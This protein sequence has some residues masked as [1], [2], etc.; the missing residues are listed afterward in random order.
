MQRNTPGKRGTADED[1]NQDCAVR[2]RLRADGCAVALY[3]PVGG[4]MRLYDELT[5]ASKSTGETLSDLV[6]D[7][8]WMFLAGRDE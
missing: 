3:C 1:S 7:A 2:H 4:E 8:L 5:L 6:I